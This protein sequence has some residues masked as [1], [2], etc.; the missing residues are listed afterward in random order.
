MTIAVIAVAKRAPAVLLE[1]SHDVAGACNHAV[2]GET[3][4]VSADVPVRLRTENPDAGSQ[5]GFSNLELPFKSSTAC[6]MAKACRGFV[7]WQGG[8]WIKVEHSILQHTSSAEP[9]SPPAQPSTPAIAAEP[10]QLPPT[11]VVPRKR[12]SKTRPAFYRKL[13]RYGFPYPGIIPDRPPPPPPHVRTPALA[14]RRCRR[15]D[16]CAK[17]HRAKSSSPLLQTPPC[18][19]SAS[20]PAHN[21]AGGARPHSAASGV[22]ECNAPELL[23]SNAPQCHAYGAGDVRHRSL[24][25]RSLPISKVVAVASIKDN[26]PVCSSPVHLSRIDGYSCEQG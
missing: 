12:R 8:A 16:L 13:A 3:R 17:R 25:C 21:P 6:A 7:Q 23:T 1:W 26:V 18:R 11:W 24:L 2:R 19:A 4:G 20:Y 10:A 14:L 15:C 9:Y 22:D 5:T